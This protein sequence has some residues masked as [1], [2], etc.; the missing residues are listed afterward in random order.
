VN[1]LEAL[2]DPQ[3]FGALPAFRDL[4]TWFAWEAF[5]AAVY[6]LPM[7][8]AMLA[9]FRAHTGRTAPRESGYAEAVAIVGRQSGKSEIAA[10]LAVFEAIS[11]PREPGR[12]ETYAVLVAQ[13]ARAAL[14]TLFRYASTPF[15]ASPLLEK[16]VNGRTQ[17]TIALEN[18]TVIAAYPCRPAAVR[19]LRARVAVLDELAFFLSTDGR[20]TDT[21]MIRALR[22]TLATTSGKLIVLSS[23]Y[24]STGA[25]TISTVATMA[26][27][28]HRPSSGRHLRRR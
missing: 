16:F 26:A 10:A 12:G 1:A 7:S 22:P 21:E 25:S 24:S 6:G 13:D 20:P 23:P 28:N 15:E 3:L 8:E 4:S 19:G 5:L 2:R 17:D 27:T 14:R 9:T 18:G 11:A